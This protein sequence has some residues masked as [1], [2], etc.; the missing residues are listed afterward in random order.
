M[1]TRR[2]M[3]TKVGASLASTLASAQDETRP[4]R[5]PF[6]H[7][8]GRGSLLIQARVNGKPA[9]LIVDTG[10]SHT[11]LRPAL[12]GIAASELARPR[13]GGGVVGDAVGREVSLEVGDHVWPRRSVS[14]MDLTQALAA[15]TER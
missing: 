1:S 5:V 2:Q 3:F 11:I 14:V 12:L 9:V 7:A 15:Y 13:I 4:V 8:A 6:R 10:S